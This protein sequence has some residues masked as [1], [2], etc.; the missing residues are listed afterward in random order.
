MTGTCRDCRIWLLRKQVRYEDGTERVLTSFGEGEGFCRFLQ[1]LTKAEFGCNKFVQ[2]D[3]QNYEDQIDIAV[4]PGAPWQN[5]MMVSCPDCSGKGSA[6]ESACHNCAGT[7]KV[8]RYDDGEIVSERIRKH[9]IDVALDAYV[10][11]V[12]NHFEDKAMISQGNE[13]LE[14][15]IKRL[16]ANRDWLMPILVE[17]MRNIP[18]DEID[19]TVLKPLPKPDVT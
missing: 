8:R 6:G 15:E 16:N 4:K 3:K 5:W 17:R 9:P 13:A 11:L 2:T 18:G 7:S 19:G 12:A 1:S 10:A 14:A